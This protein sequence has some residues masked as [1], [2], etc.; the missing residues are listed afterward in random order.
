MKKQSASKSF[1][2]LG[3]ANIVVKILAIIYIPFQTYIMGNEGNGIVAKG[4]TIFTFLYSFSNAGL[5]N[6]ISKLVSEQ[7]AHR[8]Y[9]A[10]A[11]ILKCSFFVLLGLGVAVALFMSLG[12]KA[13]A[14][15]WLVDEHDAYL[16]LIVLSP[17]LIFTSVSCALR[18]YFQG[19]QNMIPVAISNV[20][21]QLLNSVFTVV[22]AWILIKNGKVYGAAGTAVGTLIAAVG[23]AVF[24]CYIFFIVIGKQRKSEIH[25]TSHELPQ[26]STRK[27][28][29]EITRY[30]LPAILNTVAVCAASIIDNSA[31][32]R[33]EKAGY[34][35]KAA[36]DL[37]GIYSYQYNRLFTLAI[38]FSTALVTSVIPAISEAIA[39]KN[40]KL[41]KHRVNE[42]YKAIYLV[43]IPSIMGLTFLAQPIISLV[44]VN[45]DSGADLVTLGVWTAILMTIQSVQTGVLIAAG[46]P[47]APSVN[48]IIGMAVKIALNY[49]L[50]AIP[51]I[52][53]NGAI[54][55]SGVGWE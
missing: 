37:F 19:R 6:A 52:N 39:L 47:T 11:K 24:L 30:S 40:H 8:N 3:T 42:S 35:L 34:T 26:P 15:S 21:E 4:M 53:I 7:T 23:A 28:Y 44:F 27:I 54:I 43:T 2:I 45:H 25:R 17:T 38:A 49:Q 20:L 46:R 36:R 55:G 51:S 5:P 33:L 12:A 14:D 41:V 31:T 13:L 9:K 48:L 32:S 22:F 18:G 50:I 29:K 1:A 10:A 16:M